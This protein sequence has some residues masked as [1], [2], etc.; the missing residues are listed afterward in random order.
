MADTGFDVAHVEAAAPAAG[1][2]YVP[3]AP[4]ASPMPIAG[5]PGMSTTPQAEKNDSAGSF[6]RGAAPQQAAA[7]ASSGGD[8]SD[9]ERKH[10][11]EF[12][13]KYGATLSA[14]QNRVTNQIANRY[15]RNNATVR[16]VDLEFSK[17]AN[18]MAVRKQ[19]DKDH[20]P[21]SFAR[22]AL[23]LP[24]VRQQI[25]KMAGDVNVWKAAFGMI[26][27][28]MKSPPPKELYAEAKR[29]MGQ[30][31]VTDY[32]ANEFMPLARKNTTVIQG[33]IDEK[34]DMGALQKLATDVMPSAGGMGGAPMSPEAMKAM[35]QA[36]KH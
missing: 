17:M 13:A 25:A 30:E 1:S 27:E 26:S 36:Q 24:E 3:A 32:M 22:N 23:A 14:Y 33:A 34:T 28:T 15:Y 9:A 19:Y 16:R 29:F 21:F 12:L 6:Q 10:E 20:D 2:S 5:M 31:Q 18:Y 35:Q 4:K 8:V 11:K 7:P